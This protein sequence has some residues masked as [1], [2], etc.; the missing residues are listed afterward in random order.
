MVWDP[1]VSQALGAFGVL[2][3]ALGGDGTGVARR[4]GPAAADRSRSAC[5][6]TRRR[7]VTSCARPDCRNAA[8][9]SRHSG[10]HG[11]ALP[12]GSRPGRRPPQQARGLLQRN[13]RQLPELED[14]LE[15]SE[16]AP[17]S[18]S[19][20][21]RWASRRWGQPRGL[22]GDRARLARTPRGPDAACPGLSRFVSR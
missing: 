12:R 10:R 8:A 20:I 5:R 3:L 21:L 11:D 9:G 15:R 13:H 19:P 7:I 4:V 16:N 14:V 2:R 6:D 17:V 18:A 22:D 1:N